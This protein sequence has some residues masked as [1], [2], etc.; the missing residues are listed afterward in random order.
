MGSLRGLA[1]IDYSMADTPTSNRKR[2]VKDRGSDRLWAWT[3]NQYQS[4]RKRKPPT[5]S[6]QPALSLRWQSVN[7]DLIP[8]LEPC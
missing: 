4:P 3:P 8:R 1:G 7:V 5:I 6:G 2:L